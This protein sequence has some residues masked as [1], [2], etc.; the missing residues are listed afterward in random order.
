MKNM[1]VILNALLWFAIAL[2]AW[3]PAQSQ[4]SFKIEYAT[5]EDDI[6]NSGAVDPAGN[7][8][9]V[10]TRLMAYSDTAYGLLMKIYNSGLYRTMLISKPDTNISYATCTLLESGNLFV[11]GISQKQGSDK[12]DLLVAMVIDT[13][14]NVLSE[15]TIS[16]PAGYINY[17]AQEAI[18]TKQGNIALAALVGYWNGFRIKYDNYLLKLAPNGDT[19]ITHVYKTGIDIFDSQPYCWRKMPQSNDLMLIGRCF[20]ISNQNELEFFDEDLNLIRFNRLN[21]P[22][23][24]G[25]LQFSSEIWLNSTQFLMTQHMVDHSGP[26]NEYYI[27]VYR[28]DTSGH[29]FQEL[30]LDH[31]DTI[32]YIAFYKSMACYD[33]T[34]VYIGGFQSYNV[35]PIDLPTNVYLYLIDRDMNLIGTSTLGGDTYYHANFVL[36]TPDKGCLIMTQRY[37]SLPYF[38]TDAVIWK[39]M[40]EDMTIVTSVE[41]IPQK[42]ITTLTWPNPTQNE[43]YISLTSFSYGETIRLLLSDIQ[44]RKCLDKQVQVKGNVLKVSLEKIRKG[45]YVFDLASNTSNNKQTGRIIKN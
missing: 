3:Q 28:L 31:I 25:G 24:M 17:S 5:P 43:V 41:E 30:R 8:Y 9:I 33:D 23:Y 14:L 20:N 6:I 12:F 10:G 40:P 4:A 13:A 1:W 18:L 21:D 29:Y 38:E 34:N 45:I 39:V 42:L 27:G 11:T 2:A 32:D 22:T 35:G 26:V 16:L 19:L 15:K 7:A 44:G 36:A 37:D